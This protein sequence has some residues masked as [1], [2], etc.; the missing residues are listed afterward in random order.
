MTGTKTSND[1]TND[2][3]DT[4]TLVVDPDDIIDAMRRNARNA[5]TTRSHRL[6]FNRPLEGRVTASIHVREKGTYW[7]N[8]KTAPLTL[9]PKQFINDDATDNTDHPEQWEIYEAAKDV[10]NVDNLE[11]VSDEAIDE[12]WTVHLEH[13]EAAV[14]A[15][16]KS[17]VDIH[18]HKHGPNVEPR[19]VAVEYTDE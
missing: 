1:S 11:D 2:S 14:R 15:N 19:I 8:P 13:W 10:D 4:L 3:T 18:E 6:R 7:P 12:C 9:H 17:K 16:L 5:N